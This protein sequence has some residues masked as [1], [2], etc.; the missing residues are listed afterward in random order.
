VQCDDC[1]CEFQVLAIDGGVTKRP[2]NCPYCGGTNVRTAPP[3]DVADRAK[4]VRD[5]AE[6]GYEGT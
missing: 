2:T 6:K 3:S 1:K 5:A 4:A